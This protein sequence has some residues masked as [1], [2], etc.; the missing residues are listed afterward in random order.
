MPVPGHR[1]LLFLRYVA[2]GDFYL[3]GKSVELAG[4]RA[5]PNSREDV[6]KAENGTW[7]FQDQDDETMLYTVEGILRQQKGE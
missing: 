2:D 5:V 6:E 7:P 3:M 4:G 1:Y